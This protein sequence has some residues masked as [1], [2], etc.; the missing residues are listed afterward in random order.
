[1]DNL[2]TEYSLVAAAIK[3]GEARV[4]MRDALYRRCEGD[5][6]LCT[7]DA[8]AF[9]R[10]L[11]ITEPSPE[12][13]VEPL[14]SVAETVHGFSDALPPIVLPVRGS[15][16]RSQSAEFARLSRSSHGGVMEPL[17]VTSCL[18]Q[19]GSFVGRVP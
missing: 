8:I 18:F 9:T 17:P 4:L 3:L 19:E 1:M 14:A 11:G 16:V 15:Y 12:T 5:L 6:M 7:V 10:F 2:V 13:A